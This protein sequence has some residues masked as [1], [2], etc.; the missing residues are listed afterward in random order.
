MKYILISLKLKDKN[1]SFTDVEIFFN[2][3]NRFNFKKSIFQLLDLMPS[4]L[5]KSINLWV[6]KFILNLSNSNFYLREELINELRFNEGDIIIDSLFEIDNSFTNLPY[7]G[8]IH[9]VKGKTFEAVLL[10]LKSGYKT[11]INEF[12]KK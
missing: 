3:T 4:T 7:L 12:I 10:I 2:T 11:K 8:T 1:V 5:G 6:D 9:K